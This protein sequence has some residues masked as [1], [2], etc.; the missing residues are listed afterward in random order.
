V[1]GKKYPLQYNM[2][3]TLTKFRLQKVIIPDSEQKLI[4]LNLP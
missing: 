4:Y 2:V 1:D 3:K